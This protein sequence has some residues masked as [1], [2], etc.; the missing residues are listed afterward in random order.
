MWYCACV[1]AC[2]CA[3]LWCISDRD[4]TNL[5]PTHKLAHLSQINTVLRLLS[6]ILSS[7]KIHTDSP[8]FNPQSQFAWQIIVHS[9]RQDYNEKHTSLNVLASENLAIS[10]ANIMLYG[11]NIFDSFNTKTMT[12]CLH[13]PW[14]WIMHMDTTDTIFNLPHIIDALG[15]SAYFRKP[16]HNQT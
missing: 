4:R 8:N 5:A 2:V 7:A 3:V 1:V 15:D 13:H 6:N 10:E 9:A 14:S 11:L 12:N 16:F